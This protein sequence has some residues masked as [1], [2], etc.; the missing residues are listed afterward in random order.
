MA[1]RIASL[2]HNRIQIGITARMAIHSPWR[3]VR[4]MSRTEWRRRPSSAAIIGEVAS[5]RPRP[6]INGAK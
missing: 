1:S 3:T 6:K 4:R 5:M 2:F